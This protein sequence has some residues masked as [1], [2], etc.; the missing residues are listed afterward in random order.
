V[1]SDVSGEHEAL[2]A[3]LDHDERG[4][5]DVPHAAERERE[6]RRELDALVKG[7]RPQ[8]RERPAR[9]LRVEEGKG[10]PVPRVTGPVRVARVLLVQVGGVGPED[11]EQRGRGGRRVNG[12]AITRLRDPRDV[13]G[14]VDVGVGQDDR[15]E[16]SRIE[17]RIGPVLP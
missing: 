1:L 15:V 16:C 17:R 7:D 12:P 13:A 10:R 2:P 11:L 6:T 9:V 3:R 5:E 14:M 8:E 4:P